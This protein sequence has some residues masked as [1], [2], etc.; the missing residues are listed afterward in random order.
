[1]HPMMRE[2]PKII[3]FGKLLLYIHAGTT[4]LT[5]LISNAIFIMRS[6]IFT[7]QEMAHKNNVCHGCPL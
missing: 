1:M 2:G 7:K 3:T 5:N 4:A 6:E